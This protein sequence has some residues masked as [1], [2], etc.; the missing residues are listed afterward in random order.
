MNNIKM[1]LYDRADTSE[2]I[3]VKKTSSSKGSNIF[4]Y[5]RFLDR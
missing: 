1:L 4:Q 3:D 5:L 2:G